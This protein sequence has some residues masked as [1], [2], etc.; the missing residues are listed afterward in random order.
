[1]AARALHVRGR[2]LPEGEPVQWWIVDGTLRSEAVLGAETIFGA[3]LRYKGHEWVPNPPAFSQI[4]ATAEAQCG[5]H[6]AP[7]EDLAEAFRIARRHAHVNGF[8]VGRTIFVEPALAWFAGRISDAEATRAIAD[9][10]QRLCALWQD[11]APGS[12]R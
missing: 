11:A 12:A 7:E 9:S 8:A 5:L 4:S 2:G 6:E 10:F 3:F 1:M